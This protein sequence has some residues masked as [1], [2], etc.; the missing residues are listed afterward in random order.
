[1][2]NLVRFVFGTLIDYYSY[3]QLINLMNNRIGTPLMN[4]YFWRTE[5]IFL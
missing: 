5:R 3:C 4:A 1:M 2:R